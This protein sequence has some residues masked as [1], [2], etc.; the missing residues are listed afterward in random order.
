MGFIAQFTTDIRHISGKD[1][2]TADCLSRINEVSMT[3]YT[4]LE[5]EQKQDEE[6]NAILR[7]NSNPKLQLITF[8]D[9][10]KTICDT[11][12]SR[13][14]PFIPQKLRKSYLL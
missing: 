10:T 3:N 11:T 5:A 12:T 8:P 1:N 9:D 2:I 13:V 6:L 4:N 14:K 7:A